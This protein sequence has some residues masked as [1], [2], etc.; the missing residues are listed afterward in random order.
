MEVP[1]SVDSKPLTYMLSPL[2]AT[3]MKNWEGGQLWLTRNKRFTPARVG[4]RWFAQVGLPACELPLT[5]A[6]N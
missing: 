4:C 1:A 3:L 2:D 5:E 6:S